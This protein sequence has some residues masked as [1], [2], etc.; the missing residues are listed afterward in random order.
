MRE[1]TREAFD[2]ILNVMGGEDGGVGFTYYMML[3]R[4]LDKRASEGCENSEQV[5]GV[6]FKFDRLLKAAKQAR[7][8][9]SP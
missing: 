6:L 2:N 1:A 7:G 9:I 3:V 8:V 5:L 4:D